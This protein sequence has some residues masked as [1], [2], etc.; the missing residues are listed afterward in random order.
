MKIRILYEE[1]IKNGVPHY[2]TVEIPDGDYMTVLEQDYQ[3]RLAD[4]ASP[5]VWDTHSHP[6][7]PLAAFGKI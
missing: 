5:H 3:M 2:T 7:P 1:D 6:A 4:A